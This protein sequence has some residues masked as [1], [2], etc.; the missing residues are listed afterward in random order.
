MK[1]NKLIILILIVFFKTETLLSNND[2]FSV[3]NIL[4][5]KKGKVSNN[6]LADKAIKKGFDQLIS[7]ILLEND[8][9]K[10]LN[11]NFNSIKQLV[12]YYR[13]SNISGENKN[14][15]EEL[16]SFSV[17]FDKNKI[18]NLFYERGISYSKISDKEIYVL[19]VLIKDNEIFIFN[20]NYFYEKWN[21]ISKNDLVEF[22]LYLENIEVIQKINKNK[23]TLINLNVNDLFKEYSKKNSALI[24][25]EDNETD[26]KKVYIKA[27]IQNKTISKS[28]KIRSQNL[29]TQKYYEKIITE[30]KKELINLV[31]SRSLIDIRTPSFLITKFILNKKSSLV[32]LKSRINNIDLIDSIYVQEFNKDYMKLRIKYLGKLENIINQ[33]KKE[34]VDLKLIKDNWIIKVL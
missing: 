24:L 16:V 19:P 1:L 5:E 29:E 32:E 26:N 6:A 7:K 4:V 12:S 9:N 30:T 10:V 14:K 31:K 13:T 17:T 23:N 27:N 28:L 34:N 3:N 11:L 8:K 22:I 2:L 33:L 15:S 21:N 18:H 20:N 25:I